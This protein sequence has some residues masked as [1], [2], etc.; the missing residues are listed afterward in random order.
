ML[1]LSGPAIQHRCGLNRPCDWYDCKRAHADRDTLQCPSA[2]SRATVSGAKPTQRLA[3]RSTGM[4]Q[5]IAVEF[6][7]MWRLSWEGQRASSRHTCLRGRCPGCAWARPAA[8]R[9]RQRAAGAG[10]AKAPTRPRGQPA[11]EAAQLWPSRRPRRGRPQR[12]PCTD[13][14]SQGHPMTAWGAEADHNDAPALIVKVMQLHGLCSQKIGS[15][16]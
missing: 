2:D 8:G 11:T 7:G 5:R 3:L 13:S 16:E 4:R 12:C 1:C 14:Q 6:S 15:W 10:G 9:R